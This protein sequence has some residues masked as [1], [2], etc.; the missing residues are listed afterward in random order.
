MEGM[1]L[2]PHLLRF[3]VPR[4]PSLQMT[5]SK[6]SSP[7]CL[8]PWPRLIFWSP[9]FKSLCDMLP[10]SLFWMADSCAATS[11]LG[12]RS[13]SPRMLAFPSSLGL[14]RLWAIKPCFRPSPTFMSIFGG[15][16]WWRMSSGLFL[17]VIPAKPDS[18]DAFIFPL[19]SLTFPLFSKKFT[20]TLCLCQ[21]LIS[22]VTLFRPAVLCCLGLNGGL[23]G[24]KLRKPLGIL[25]LRRFFVGGVGWLKLSW[26]MVLLLLPL[27]GIWR[28]NMAFTTSRFPPTILRRMAWS[29]GNIHFNV[30]E[31]LMKACENDHSQWVTMAPVVFWADRVTICRLTGYS[32]FF[33]AHGIEAV[34][35]FDVVEAT[36][37]LPP[38]EVP[39]LTKCLI[40]HHAQQLL[41]RPEDLHD[42]AD[43]VLKAC[44]ISAAQFVA[45][46]ASTIQDYDFSVGSLVLVRNSHIEKELN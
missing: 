37:L 32:P 46:F 26:I 20:S 12:T 38:L 3:P 40:A 35:P 39:T 36:Y 6:S 43:Q 42:M 30:R 16:C 4:R 41:K 21:W 31:S 29:R 33:M 18:S 15:L 2:F 11:N 45:R 14:M 5:S 13:S 17:P 44:K 9:S 25:S 1:C 23:S 19:S 27:Q 34:L 28:R 10:S 8:N 24:R 7:S 22:S